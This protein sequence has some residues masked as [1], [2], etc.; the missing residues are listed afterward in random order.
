LKKERKKIDVTHQSFYT[1]GKV[2]FR[3]LALK[4]VHKSPRSGND[5]VGAKIKSVYNNRLKQQ[6]G[7]SS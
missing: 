5:D 1:E 6:T 4:E 3:S 2:E 7:T